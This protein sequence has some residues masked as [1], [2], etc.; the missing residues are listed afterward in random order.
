NLGGGR[1]L[2]RGLVVVE[3]ALALTLLAC[4]GLALRS[5]W[6]LTRVDLGVRTDHILTF[7]LPVPR[8]RF[9]QPERIN[10]YFRQMLEKIESVPGIE[11]AALSTGM[12]LRGTGGAVPFRVAGEAPLDEGARHT[13]GFQTVT[14]GYFQTFGMRVTQGRQFTAQDT[15]DTMR[16]GMVNETF[17]KKYFSGAN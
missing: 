10:P 8:A 15:A 2:R 17:V 6:N 12:P 13:T 9:P 11:A 5:F 14:P 7:L 16:G 3:F 4:G 1:G